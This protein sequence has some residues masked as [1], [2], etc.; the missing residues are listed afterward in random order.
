MRYALLHRDTT[1]TALACSAHV[2][3]AE[4]P[5]VREAA[6]LLA[7]TRRIRAA[8]AAE[9][10]AAIAEARAAARAEGLATARAEAEAELGARLFALEAEAAEARLAL[11]EQLVDLAIGIVRRIAG[12][13]G[14]GPLVAALAARAT[15]D[16]LPDAQ[17]VVRVHPAALAA[18]RARLPASVEVIGDPATA[19]TDC[20]IET[21]L[22]RTLAG[23]DVQLA[24]VRR[25]LGAAHAEALRRAG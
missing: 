7:E 5:L 10:E 11:R 6:D 13:L 18:A 12:D 16:M 4:A 17:V 22:G 20:L 2:P 24:A 21:P 1:L 9:V 3:A 25:T 8:A 14:D 23:L 15:A 19:P